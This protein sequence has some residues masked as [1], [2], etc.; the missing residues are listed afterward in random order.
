MSLKTN[1]GRTELGG[2]EA[3]ARISVTQ[4]GDTVQVAFT[5]HRWTA[6][7]FRMSASNATAYSKQLQALEGAEAFGSESG[8]SAA[9]LK[10]YHYVMSMPYFDNQDSLAVDAGV[11]V[12]A[13]ASERHHA[14]I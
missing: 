14:S 3:V 2:Y 13:T 5:E 10:S 7:T 11:E 1:A 8:T 12:Y 9:K 4:V 6:D